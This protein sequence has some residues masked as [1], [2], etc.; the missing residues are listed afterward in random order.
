MFSKIF[1]TVRHE[2]MINDSFYLRNKNKK[3]SKSKYC[4]GLLL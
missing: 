2:Y 1:M 4:K 3:Y